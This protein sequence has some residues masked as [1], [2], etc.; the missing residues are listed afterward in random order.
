MA[1]RFGQ[2]S[3][4]HDDHKV[5]REFERLAQDNEAIAA[6]VEAV[7]PEDMTVDDANGNTGKTK[8]E[9]TSEIKN[10][11]WALTVEHNQRI[12]SRKTV[13]DLTIHDTGRSTEKYKLVTWWDIQE[14][15]LTPDLGTI[16]EATRVLMKVFAGTSPEQ[17]LS[18]LTGGLQHTMSVYEYFDYNNYIMK[19]K[20][21]NDEQAPDAWKYYGTNE[22]GTK[23]WQ[24]VSF[25]ICIAVP[26]DK[27]DT[28]VTS[29]MIIP[30]GWYVTKVDVHVTTA[31][32][33]ATTFNPT[34]KVDLSYFGG[35]INL[36]DT[37]VVNLKEDG[38]FTTN[39]YIENDSGTNTTVKVTVTPDGSTAGVGVA[40]VWCMRIL[41]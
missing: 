30:D 27:D 2:T 15:S 35:A 26:F 21:V 4:I 40:Y 25:P 41:S 3:F 28:V 38:L 17:F 32:Y 22:S 13:Q 7:L 9:I 23:G 19:V 1:T 36:I 37:D 39:W 33:K 5:Q 11:I 20:L 18:W 6:A 16:P 14:Q 8:D 29:N 24:S 10:N 12:V 34:V 31:F